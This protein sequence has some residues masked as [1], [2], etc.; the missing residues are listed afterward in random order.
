[1]KTNPKGNNACLMWLPAI[2]VFLFNISFCRVGLLNF[3]EGACQN[4]TNIN[5]KP[6]LYIRGRGYEL[7][8]AGRRVLRSARTRIMAGFLVNNRGVPKFKGHGE[9]WG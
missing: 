2:Y 7:A 1:M 3:I 9:G 8:P 4:I 6:F 5:S